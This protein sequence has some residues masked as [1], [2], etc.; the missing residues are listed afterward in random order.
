M[1]LSKIEEIVEKQLAQVQ[2]A[3][4]DYFVT[5]HYRSGGGVTRLPIDYTSPH[6]ATEE[7]AFKYAKSKNTSQV[8]AVAHRKSDG[9]RNTW[10]T[11]DGW[12][13]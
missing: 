7:E 6:F 8:I 3:G 9:A 11:P 1:K 10:L 12:T 5:R 4:G 13:S 2:M